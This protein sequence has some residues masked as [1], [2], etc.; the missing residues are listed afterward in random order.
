MQ[1]SWYIAAHIWKIYNFKIE[2]VPFII[3]FSNE[4]TTVVK[5]EEYAV[6]VV[7]L[8]FSSGRYINR[9]KSANLKLLIDK[10]LLRGTR[11]QYAGVPHR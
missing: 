10:T 2:V 7:S 1:E 9:R 4:L 3:N 8:H 11:D 5:F 6:S